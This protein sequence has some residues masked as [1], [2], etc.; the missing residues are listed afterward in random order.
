LRKKKKKAERLNSKLLIS[1]LFTNGSSFFLHPFN[2]TFLETERNGGPPVQIMISVSK[3][4]FASSVS[5]NQIK[6]LIRET[7]RKNKYIVWDDFKDKPQT[8][9]LI[10]IVYLAKT[11]ET[12]SEIER[13]LIL[14]LHRLIDKDEASNR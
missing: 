4:N 3:R 13:K 1:K 8:Q 2:V 11:I 14:I 9:L 12:Y 6:R 5:R 7:Y 10:G